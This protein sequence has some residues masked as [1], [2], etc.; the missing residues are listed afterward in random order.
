MI[1]ECSFIDG[2]TMDELIKLNV[3][4]NRL[5]FIGDFY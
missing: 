2:K 5:I 3:N 4:T 1:D